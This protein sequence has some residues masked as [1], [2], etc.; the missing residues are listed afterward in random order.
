MS[1]CP[2]V[3]VMMLAAATGQVD[4]VAVCPFNSVQ[5]TYKLNTRKHLSTVLFDMP[6]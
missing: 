4:R 1:S 3:R 2:P 6:I 5:F